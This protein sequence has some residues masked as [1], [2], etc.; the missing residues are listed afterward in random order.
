MAFRVEIAPQAFEDL[1]AIA[2]YIRE[3]GSFAVS[4]KWFNGI[5]DAIASLKELPARCPIAAES[6]DIGQE[7]RLLLHGGRNRSY[8]IYYT[9]DYETPSSGTVRVFHVRHWARKEVSELQDLIDDLADEAS[10]E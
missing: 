2:D 7:V 4:A 5:I 9:V 10:G 1:D 8:K 6:E 3:H